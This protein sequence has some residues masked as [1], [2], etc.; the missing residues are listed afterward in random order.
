LWSYQGRG[1]KLAQYRAPSW[2]WAA[3]DPENGIEVHWTHGLYDFFGG[4]LGESNM[5]KLKAQVLD[6]KVKVQ[7]LDCQTTP[8]GNDFYGAI[9]CGYLTLRGYW[10]SWARAK[11]YGKDVIWSSPPAINRYDR[12]FFSWALFGSGSGEEV[13][14]SFDEYY[15]N[16]NADVFRV[17]SIL[18]IGRWSGSYCH[19]GRQFALLL[20]PTSGE[21]QFRRIGL[22]E[23]PYRYDMFDFEADGWEVKNVTII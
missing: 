22:A 4:D 19:N 20:E 14:C 8:K 13:I 10:I 5:G 18:Q 9:V 21:G 23:L 15:D 11:Q 17:L 7:V 1:Q 12:P 3:L 2:S 6:D 16:E